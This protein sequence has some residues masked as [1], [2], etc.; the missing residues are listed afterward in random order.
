MNTYTHMNARTNRY[1][2]ENAR[3]YSLWGDS[4]MFVASY[5]KRFLHFQEEPISKG[6]HNVSAKKATTIFTDSG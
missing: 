2:N 3:K 6:L 1:T 5:F 4:E